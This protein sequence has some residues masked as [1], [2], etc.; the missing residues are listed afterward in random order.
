MDSCRLTVPLSWFTLFYFFKENKREIGNRLSVIGGSSTDYRS[1]ITD[2]L[3][4]DYHKFI[5]QL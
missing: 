1:Q 3:L 4:L 2:Y 5:S